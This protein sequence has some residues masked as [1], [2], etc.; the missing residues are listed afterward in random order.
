[1]IGFCLP[2]Y[3][4]SSCAHL[5]RINIVFEGFR[6]Y[7]YCLPELWYKELEEIFSVEDLQTISL[8]IA[9]IYTDLGTA[10]NSYLFLH[11]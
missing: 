4:I 5:T 3:L 11:S 8:Q 10:I 9:G 1:M 7:L 6:Q 2:L